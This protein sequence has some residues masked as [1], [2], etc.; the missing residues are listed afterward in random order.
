M[1]QTSDGRLPQ[2]VV[3]G[4][5]KAVSTTLHHYL[6]KHPNIFMCTPKEPHF[7]SHPDVY[8]QGLPWYKNLFAGAKRDQICG[9]ASTTYTRWPQFGDVASRLAQVVPKVKLIYILRNPVYR[10]YSHYGHDMRPG[11]TMSFEEALQRYPVYVNVSLYMSQIHRYL[12]FFKRDAFHFLLLEDLQEAPVQ[13]LQGVQ[14]FLGLDI[15]NLVGKDAELR[16]N[17]GG[18]GHYLWFEMMSVI[19]AHPI[20]LNVKRLIP[21]SIRKLMFS[22]LKRSPIGQRVMDSYQLPP[23]KKETRQRLLDVFQKPNEELASFLSRD[24]SIWFLGE[25]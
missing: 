16:A 13:V 4:A 22:G 11:V 21:E 24:L 10:A 6:C 12:R 5:A 25:L 20:L 14:S 23:M 18:A 15:Q 8:S 19:E 9:E 7:F 1:D 3:V 17:V 2:F